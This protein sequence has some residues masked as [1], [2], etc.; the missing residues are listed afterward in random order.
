MR[1]QS[2]VD[3]GVDVVT[4]HVDSPKVRSL[5]RREA[6]DLF[7][8]LSRQRFGTGPPKAISP[9]P[10]GTGAPIDAEIRRTTYSGASPF[11]TDSRW[12]EGW[13]GEEF[14]LRPGRFR[15]GQEGR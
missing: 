5:H 7:L 4:G 10:N 6:R 15:R 2:L 8:R 13:H 11:R 3:Q 12:F 1:S 9:A 14:A